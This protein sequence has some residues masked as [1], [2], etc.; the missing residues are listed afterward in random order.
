MQYKLLGR[1]GLR[2][3]ELCLGTMTFGE[4]WGWGGGVEECRKMFDAFAAA[5]GNFLDTANLY[6]NGTSEQIVGDLIAAD[7]GRWVLATKFSL[8]VGDHVNASGNHR[9]NMVQSLEASLRRLKT[10]YIDLYWLH[11]WDFTTPLEEIM[12][13]FDDLVRAGK[14]LYAGVSDT[15]AWIVAR[16]NT[17]AELRGWS[18]FVGLQ[19]QYS[20]LE[21]SVERDLLPMAE[22][23]GLGVT[24]WS[25][26]GA[27]VLSG[28]YN[29][30]GAAE[31]ARLKVMQNPSYTNEYLTPRN[32]QIAAEV[33][34]VAR[35]VGRSPSQVALRWL[36]Q[37]P[38]PSIPILGARKL[39]QIQ[40]NLN[41]VEFSLSVEQTKRLDRASVIDLGFPHSFL[42][43]PMV[44]DFAFGGQL[45]RIANPNDPLPLA[46]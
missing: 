5:G 30:A 6:T 45:A 20:L 24:A 33:V 44:R 36:L 34:E 9:K 21:R 39:A 18:P 16:A 13:A 19:I 11:A 32:L 46:A 7:R 14:I 31:G 41:C 28:K 4:N 23:L 2:V 42:V 1:S 17:L 26:L 27:G 10:D 25:P 8:S 22:A 15:P 35:E 40:D 38:V 12:R 3:S 29:Q 43:S 37:K